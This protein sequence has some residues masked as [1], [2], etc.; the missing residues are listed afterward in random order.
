MDAAAPQHV[1]PLGGI[2]S[3][4]VHVREPY[5]SAR[6]EPQA[7]SWEEAVLDWHEQVS[8]VFQRRYRAGMAEPTGDGSSAGGKSADKAAAQTVAAQ[9]AG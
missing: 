8:N 3:E 5:L 2:E 4:V 1:L 7:G 6:W 9:V